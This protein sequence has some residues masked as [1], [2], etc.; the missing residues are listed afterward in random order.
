[1]KMIMHNEG[2]FKITCCSIC[3]LLGSDT[4]NREKITDRY[5]RLKYS[6]MHGL[7][8]TESNSVIPGSLLKIPD[9]CP[10]DDYEE[11]F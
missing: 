10:L 5:C 2:V 7:G 1:M 4:T 9:M 11:L 6:I 8:F 3:P